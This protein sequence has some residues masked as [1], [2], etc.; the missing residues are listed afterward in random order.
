MTLGTHRARWVDL[1]TEYEPHGGTFSVEPVVD[2]LSQGVQ[3]VGIGSGLALYGTGTYGTA[4]YAGAGRRQ[5]YNTLPLGSEGRTFV[6]KM[7]YSGQETFRIF[8]YHP[9]LRPETAS[10]T[11]TE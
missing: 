6:L 2:G 1:R 3:A 5:S 9:G 8:S 11:F 10:R 7:T 4:V